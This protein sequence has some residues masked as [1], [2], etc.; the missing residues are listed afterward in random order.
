[1]TSPM[2]S[3]NQ[4]TCQAIVD[5]R[6]LLAARIV[7]RHYWMR[8][9]LAPRYGEDG[10]SQ[11][12]ADAKY[13]LDALAQAIAAGRSALFVDYVAWAKIFL[14]SRGIPVQ[15]LAEN[16]EACLKTLEEVL[17]R[18]QGA[19]A[20]HYILDSL[21]SLPALP[22][23]TPSYLSPDRPLADLAR[24]YLDALL[25][26]DRREASQLV[27]DAVHGGTPVRDI[28]LHVFQRSQYEIGRLW[29][30]NQICVAQEHLCTA[31]TRLIR[32]QLYSFIFGTERKNRRVVAACVGGDS[33]EI[34]VRMVADFFEMD[35]WDTFYLGADVPTASIVQTVVDRRAHVLA[36]S[37]TLLTHVSSVAD[38]I[39]AVR[40]SPG[41]DEVT[42]L[43]GGHP[44]NVSPELWREVGADGC[45]ADAVRAVDLADQLMPREAAL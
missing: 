23:T 40:T 12:V 16:L 18:D 38:L 45:A 14:G 25:N 20:A 31:A 19:I 43:V 17:P 1:M 24:R 34:G 9:D 29:Q 4:T 30:T 33:H 21:S 2:R 7:A 36:V 22:T 27:M 8:A 35:G 13:H 5:Q 39:A 26:A 6:D 28:Y 41:C 44:F 10:R 37:A 32:S 15:L 42:I 3:E 11:C